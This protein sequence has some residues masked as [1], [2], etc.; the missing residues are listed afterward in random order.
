MHL[1]N[2]RLSLFCNFLCRAAERYTTLQNRMWQNG[3]QLQNLI[4]EV[5][6][7]PTSS[8][9]N[10]DSSCRCRCPQWVKSAGL[11]VGPS[12][13]VHPGK[14]TF[15]ESACMSQTGHI[16]T[17]DYVR[18]ICHLCHRSRIIAEW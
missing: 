12:F 1:E 18:F 15:F 11:V 5:M 8:D 17:Y 9:R 10:V 13:P 16:L 4:P 14:Q 3:T 6:A 2:F 7:S